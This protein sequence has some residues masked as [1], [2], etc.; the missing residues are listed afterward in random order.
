MLVTAYI[1]VA[2][3]H[4]D[5]AWFLMMED[6]TPESR[7]IG[8]IVAILLFAVDFTIYLIIDDYTIN[9]MVNKKSKRKR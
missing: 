1:A 6:F 2:L 3:Y 8:F 9:Y 4:W 5:S 7:V